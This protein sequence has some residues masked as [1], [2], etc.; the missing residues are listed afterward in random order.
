MWFSQ[1]INSGAQTLPGQGGPGGGQS[2][3][4]GRNTFPII[5]IVLPVHLYESAVLPG[6]DQ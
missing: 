3:V 1:F 2:G 6:R 4:E 5:N